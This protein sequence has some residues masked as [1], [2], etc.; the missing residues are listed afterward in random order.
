[1]ELY[2]EKNDT[3]VGDSHSKDINYYD[4][5]EEEVFNTEGGG[6][7][8][9][10]FKN[11]TWPM[12]TIVM[13]KIQFGLGILS[14][15]EAIASLGAV[16]GVIILVFLAAVT[17]YG[18]IVTYQFKMKH[19]SVHSVSDIAYVMGG[20]PAKI[21]VFIFFVLYIGFVLGSSMLSV[22]I[23]F[24]AITAHG[25][26]TVVFTFVS[27]VIICLVGSLRTYRMLSYLAWVG[28]I[29]I[30][31]S[32]L[33]VTIA[34][35][36][37][38]RPAAAPSTGP[39]DKQVGATTTASFG[40]AFMGIVNLLFAY[41]ASPMFITIISELRNPKDFPKALY[42]C[43]GSITAVYLALGIP[44]YTSIGVYTTSPSLG[45]AGQTIKRIACEYTYLFKKINY[46]SDKLLDGVALIGLVA[47]ASNICHSL[48]KAIFVQSMR[49]SSHLNRNTWKFWTVWIS[50]VLG[51]S[52]FAFIIASVIPF[53]SSLLGLIGALFSSF[54]CIWFCSVVW[55]YEFWSTGEGDQRSWLAGFKNKT[56]KQYLLAS[57]NCFM[58]LVGLLITGA[59]LYASG[60]S[61]K[62]LFDKGQIGSPFSCADT[63]STS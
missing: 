17:T 37:N 14:V 20:E 32:V 12:A 21:G 55:F 15:P 33:I 4:A 57:L 58:I 30:L 35:G 26:C 23:A 47:G 18:S 1:M 56:F 31:A 5:N 36:V 49:K 41:A 53:F 34:V 13:I 40:D 27:L 59:G 29:S 48:A 11:L 46:K 62:S 9:L 54:F 63:S 19:R 60:S 25:T 22:S 7:D 51:V 50:C 8:K 42:I 44:I 2:K 28:V 39:Y 38:D 3:R 52:V 24:N 16:P 43:Q 10:D 61:I 45:V 6:E